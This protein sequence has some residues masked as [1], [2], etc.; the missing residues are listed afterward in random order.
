MYIYIDNSVSTEYTYELRYNKSISPNKVPDFS[1][2]G[3]FD[4]VFSDLS[5]FLSSMSCFPSLA[6]PFV[7][8]SS[9]PTDS[10]D[11]SR[12]AFGGRPGPR[13][14]LFSLGEE[15]MLEHDIL[16][17]LLSEFDS[18]LRLLVSSKRG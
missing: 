8:T 11:I 3:F 4:E 6:S 1:L 14:T 17:S 12:S 15:G 2:L 5:L 7:K 10:S 9:S 18:V 16:G 13:F